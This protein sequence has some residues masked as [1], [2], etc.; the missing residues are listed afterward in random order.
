[1]HLFPKQCLHLFPKQC[2]HLFPKQCLHFRVLLCVNRNVFVVLVQIP[3]LLYEGVR[4][5]KVLDLYHSELHQPI[6]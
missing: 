4:F 5:M 3:P 6:P 2:L 1:M